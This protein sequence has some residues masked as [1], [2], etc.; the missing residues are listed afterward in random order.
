MQALQ[1]P[2]ISVGRLVRLACLRH[3]ASVHPEPGSNS[4]KKFI[5]LFIWTF[6]FLVL[7]SFSNYLTFCSV[8]RDHFTIYYFFSQVA[9]LIYQIVLALSTYFLTFFTF[10]DISS[11]A[12]S[13]FANAFL[14]YHFF[15]PL[16]KLFFY[17]FSSFLYFLYFPKYV[18]ID[19][20]FIICQSIN[21]YVLFLFY[22]YNFNNFFFFIIRYC[23]FIFFF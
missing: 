15:T 13:F 5:F 18:K 10:F 8:F 19:W 6:Y 22:F 4:Q 12:S 21:F 7:P 3:A 9:P 2:F 1:L 23:Y 20:H 16:V 14:I 11:F 17:F